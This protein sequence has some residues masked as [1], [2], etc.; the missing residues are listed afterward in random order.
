MIKGDGTALESGLQRP[1]LDDR[2]VANLLA[3]H[4]QAGGRRQAKGGASHAGSACVKG[5]HRVGKERKY[6]AAT[7]GAEPGAVRSSGSRPPTVREESRALPNEVELVVEGGRRGRLTKGVCALGPRALKAPFLW[8]T[9]T[10][11]ARRI[12]CFKKKKPDFI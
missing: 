8:R 3:A 7:V 4:E 6:A 2:V 1:S 12:T 9:P 11:Y 10:L 5:S